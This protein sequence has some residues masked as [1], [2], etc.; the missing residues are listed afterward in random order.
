MS[1]SSITNLNLKQRVVTVGFFQADGEPRPDQLIYALAGVA[2]AMDCLESGD[3]KRG[4]DDANMM[5]NLA[6]AA[7]VL[8]GQLAARVAS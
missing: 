7:N 3:H 6:V 4:S 2:R 8:A 5:A 1:V